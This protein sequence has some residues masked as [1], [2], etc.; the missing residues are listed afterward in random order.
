MKTISPAAAIES[1]SRGTHAFRWRSIWVP[2]T[3]SIQ[4]SLSQ[5]SGL[6]FSGFLYLIVVGVLSGLWRNG[7][8]A[9]GGLL[10]GYT[11]SS[12]TWYLA[13]SEA[14]TISLN[15]RLI[16]DIGSHIVS[17][18]IA[19]EMLRPVPVLRQRVVA[20]FG[21]IL[22]RLLLCSILGITLCLLTVGAPRQWAS[23][24]LAVPSLILAV[25]C[26]IVAQHAFAALAFWLRETGATWFLYQ[27]F[28]FMLGGMLLPMQVLPKLLRK[29]ASFTP[30][31]SMAYAPARLV[32][33]HF[34]PRLIAVQIG[35]LIAL[36]L[37]ALFAF[38]KG[39]ARF[40]VVGG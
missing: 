24:V 33:G 23:I 39:E 5:R 14:V 40:Q 28:V 38:A 6:A 15:S 35:W 30:F 25:A 8:S 37:L 3:T 2:F 17:G 1:T 32:S 13:A 22:P 36:Y 31:P 11:A 7:V 21:R 4:R 16:A 9:R 10:A 34:E 26:N 18:E 27:K 20:E 12:L 29:A 19:T